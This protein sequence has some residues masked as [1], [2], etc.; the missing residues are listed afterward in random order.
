MTGTDLRVTKFNLFTE[1]LNVLKSTKL[2]IFNKIL[3][4]KKKKISAKNLQKIETTEKTQKTWYQP[5]KPKK[6]KYHGCFTK[7]RGIYHPCSFG[8]FARSAVC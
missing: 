1:K 7:N 2:S 6:P 5:K 8:L 3:T 4:I